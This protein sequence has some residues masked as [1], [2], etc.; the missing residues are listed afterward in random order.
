MSLHGWWVKL[1]AVKVTKSNN[2]KATILPSEARS[3]S[4]VQMHFCRITTSRTVLQT[5]VRFS[6]F[7]STQ[8]STWGNLVISHE[9]T[10]EVPEV[11]AQGSHWGI[12]PIHYTYVIHMLLQGLSRDVHGAYVVHFNLLSRSATSLRLIVITGRFA[13]FLLTMCLGSA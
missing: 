12:S 11:V 7:N 5:S 9:K 8:K 1:G 6:A 2:R 3:I 4:E 10:L 13:A